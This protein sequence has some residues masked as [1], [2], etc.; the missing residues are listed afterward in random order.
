[1]P[2]PYQHAAIE[3]RWQARWAAQ[4]LH[5][6]D[7][8]A[9]AAAGGPRSSA[10]KLY[11]LVE[12]PYP[13]AEGLHIGHALT[14]SGADVWGR[15]QRRR[16]HVV[17]QPMGFDSFGINAENY[18]LKVGVHPRELMAR[19]AANYRRQLTALGCGWSW[20]AELS[21]CDPGYYRWTQWVFLRLFDAGLAYQAEAPVL[22]CQSCQT[23]LAREQVEGA[24]PSGAGSAADAGGT[25]ASLGSCERCSTPVV[26]RILRQWFLRT[27]AYVERLLAGLDDLDWPAKA[28][29]RQRAWIGRRVGVDGRV[30]YRL[31]DWLISRQRYWGPPIPIVHCDRCGAVA[32]PDDELPVLLPKSIHLD[33][34]RPTRTGQSPLARFGDWVRTSCPRCGGEGRRDTDVSDTFLDSAWYFLRYPSVDV[35]DRPWDPERTAR[36]LPVDQCAGGPEHV[37]RHHLYARFVCLALH[38]R[39][40]IPFA[41]PFPRLRLHGVLTM[42]GAKMSKS[43]GNVINPDKLVADHGADVTRVGLLFTRPWD[44]DG[45]FD[46]AVLVGVER[47]LARV[48]RLATAPP[49]DGGAELDLGQTVDRVT[50]S[51]EQM[52]FNTAIAA[53]MALVGQ[54]LSLEQPPARDVRRVLVSLLAPFAPHVTEELWHTHVGDPGSV[55]TISWPGRP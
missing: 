38:D 11:N 48:W 43:R 28:K 5:E 34:L 15:M 51:I 16:G 46:P 30:S 6:V 19:T 18:A 54:L 40:L 35:P 44:A 8:T 31:R 23:V 12:F 4:R 9:V 55:H 26:E 17:L 27:T 20:D 22:W 33:V 7:L 24:D 13:S 10:R 36:W 14:Y 29:N 39:G 21:T 53:L 25:T 1:V 45:D 41:E 50:R 49:G 52:Q 47:F 3:Q 37:T 42:G 32:V 2:L